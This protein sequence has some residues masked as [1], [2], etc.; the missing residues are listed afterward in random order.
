MKKQPDGIYCDSQDKLQPSELPVLAPKFSY[1]EE[2]IIQE[3][4]IRY[5]FEGYYDTVDA[6]AF[7][8]DLIY[9]GNSSVHFY[10]PNTPLKVIHDFN[11]FKSN[12]FVTKYWSNDF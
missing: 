5:I 3:K 6:N 9:L 4:N 7:R 12:N 11:R 2:V 1:V 8:I 10:E